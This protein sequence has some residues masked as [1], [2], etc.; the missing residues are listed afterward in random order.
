MRSTEYLSF[1]KRERTGIVTLVI[2]LLAFVFAP[3]FFCHSP[4]PVAEN[5]SPQ[6]MEQLVKKEDHHWKYDTPRRYSDKEKT[7]YYTAFKKQNTTYV[8]YQSRY[9]PYQKKHTQLKVIDI[10]SADTSAFIELPGIG[11]KLASRIILFREKLG[12]FYSVQQIGEVYGLKDSVFRKIVP[13]LKCDAA[14]IKKLHINVAGKDELKQHPYIRWQIA[15]ALIAYREQ[16]GVFDSLNDLVKIN[17]IDSVVLT[18]MI[19]YLSL[20]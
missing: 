13:W 16:H 8:P 2:L 9:P 10:N 1:T 17:L 14:S 18:K 5:I 15:E 19:P 20:N 12:G 3:R 6:Q 11:S 4:K 7:K